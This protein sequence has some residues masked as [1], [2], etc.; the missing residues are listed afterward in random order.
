MLGGW[1]KA[2]VNSTN[3]LQ[4]PILALSLINSV[5]SQTLVAIHHKRRSFIY[6]LYGPI[7]S[8][9]ASLSGLGR[10]WPPAG[11]SHGCR[12][13]PRQWEHICQCWVVGLDCLHI[14]LDAD[15]PTCSYT[16]SYYECVLSYC[17]YTCMHHYY[18]QV[19]HQRGLQFQRSTPMRNLAKNLGLAS[20]STSS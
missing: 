16:M 9:T 11:C 7:H 8:P 20:P 2:T 10:Q 13:P 19:C 3:M 18:V 5:H 12:V 1:G 15:G 4:V 14:R 6:D 17:Q